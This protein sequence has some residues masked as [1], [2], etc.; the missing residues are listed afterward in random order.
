MTT[1]PTPPPSPPTTT[2]TRNV[3]AHHLACVE[4]RTMQSYELQPKHLQRLTWGQCP[5]PAKAQG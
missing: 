3:T 1:T 4:C 2:T 5:G